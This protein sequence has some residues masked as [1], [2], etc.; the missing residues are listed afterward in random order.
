MM[1][2]ACGDGTQ[3]NVDS[4][5]CELCPTGKAGTGGTC[6]QCSAGNYTSNDSDAFVSTGATKC[7]ACGAGTYDD[8]SDPSTGCVTC[9]A[10]KHQSE[11]GQI[12]CVDCPAGTIPDPSA[13]VCN[14]CDAGKYQDNPGQT[15]CTDCDT[16]KFSSSEG[17]PTCEERTRCDENIVRCPYDTYYFDERG[18]CGS[19]TRGE[20]INEQE[21]IDNCCKPY[22]T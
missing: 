3:Q 15:S 6:N 5:G 13:T 17:Q 14:D 7:V 10:G 19:P 2:D 16:G 12:E 9:P 4:T 11:T 8:D 21:D 1:C 18:Y 20:C 22:Q